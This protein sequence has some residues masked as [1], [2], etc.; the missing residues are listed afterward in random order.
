MK[1]EFRQWQLKTFSGKG[2]HLTPVELKDQTPFE[3]KRMYYITRFESEVQ[4]GDHCHKVEEEVFIQ[5]LGTSILILDRGNGKED[6]VM[7]EGDAIYVP[8]FVWHGFKSPSSDCI[9]IALSSTNYSVDRSD[10]VEN[11]DE[12]MTFRDEKLAENI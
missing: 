3:V 8:N 12:Y 9:I 11:Y 6:V 7:N 4:T 10:Y 2:Y 1:K 5:A